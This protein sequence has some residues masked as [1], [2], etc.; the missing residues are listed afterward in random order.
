MTRATFDI[1]G[2]T[3]PQSPI[4][5]SVPHAGRDYPDATARLRHPVERLRALE[6]RYADRLADRVV[7]GGVSAIVSRMPR[8]WIDLNRAESELDPAMVIGRHG[9]GLPQSVKTRGG[10]GLIPRRLTETG[11]IWRTGLTE[12][13]VASRIERHYRPY[14]T[15]LSTMLARAHARFGVAMLVDLHS[16]PPLVGS[17][18]AGSNGAGSNGAG[19]DGADPDEASIVLGDRFGT[20]CAPQLTAMAEAV[21]NRAGYRV[22]TNTPYAG[23][24]I[25]SHHA[26]RLRNVHALQVEVDR[27]LYLDDVFD[28]VGTGLPKLQAVIA[29]LSE[30]LAERLVGTTAIAAE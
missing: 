6:D 11:D 18:G 26:A 24:Y 15:I 17:N 21:F 16:M 2:P 10:L 23:G 29:L 20:T 12:E 9:G 7:E 28:G 4:I 25:V 13:D 19:P 5:L 3:I 30:S 27:S 22:V 8:L 1:Y 14:H